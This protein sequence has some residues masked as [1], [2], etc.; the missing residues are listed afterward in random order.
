MTITGK[1]GPTQDIP[2]VPWMVC[3]IGEISVSDQP[4]G[5]AKERGEATSV[6]SIAHMQPEDRL[7]MGKKRRSPQGSWQGV[8][9]ITETK[10]KVFRF[11]YHYTR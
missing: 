5:G 8:A 2:F 7:K 9:P 3:G 6:G 10:G 1:G 4:C 11:H